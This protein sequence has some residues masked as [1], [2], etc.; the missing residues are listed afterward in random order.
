[1]IISINRILR[2]PNKIYP[3]RSIFVLSFSLLI[4]SK[5]FFSFDFNPPSDECMFEGECCVSFE[6][7]PTK[8]IHTPRSYRICFKGSSFHNTTY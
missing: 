1:M 6:E 2:S 7:Q 5:D 4:V 3:K 8:T